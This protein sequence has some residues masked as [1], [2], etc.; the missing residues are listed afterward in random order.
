MP[1]Y[2]GAHGNERALLKAGQYHPLC[3]A[4]NSE[5]QGLPYMA[6]HLYLLSTLVYEWTLSS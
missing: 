4:M 1:M 3:N 6:F 5:A 2:V